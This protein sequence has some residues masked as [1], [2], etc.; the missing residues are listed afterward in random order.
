M[1]SSWGDRILIERYNKYAGVVYMNSPKSSA[2]MNTMFGGVVPRV[3]THIINM[4]KIN[5]SKFFVMISADISLLNT[6]ERKLIAFLESY[7]AFL[8]WGH[9]LARKWVLID[10]IYSM[11]GAQV[12]K[13]TR[14]TLQL[15]FTK[16]WPFGP[17]LYVALPTITVRLGGVCLP[18]LS[19]HCI[20]TYKLAIVDAC[21]NDFFCIWKFIWIHSQP[22]SSCRWFPH[23]H[24]MLQDGT[25]RWNTVRAPSTW[26][27]NH[28]S[29][30]VWDI[31]YITS[32]T[33]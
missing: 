9:N 15:F 32:T 6:H 22:A 23:H 19:F 10:E 2:S 28:L 33:V 12:V 29:G 5:T 16:L 3:H 31:I 26:I 17:H 21:I 14:N 8:W 27:N 25:W 18:Q 24:H 1:T 30:F 7:T 13:A 11:S 4:H 20:H